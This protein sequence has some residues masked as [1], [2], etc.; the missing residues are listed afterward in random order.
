MSSVQPDRLSS[1]DLKA[2]A[3]LAG[4]SVRLVKYVLEGKRGGR[5]TALQRRIKQLVEVKRRLNQLFE[6]FAVFTRT[7]QEL[8][9]G[10]DEG[11]H[12]MRKLLTEITATW[13]SQ[14]PNHE[15]MFA[16][17][18]ELRCT[19]WNE[20]LEKLSGIPASAILGKTRSEIW[21]KSE[22]GQFDDYYRRVLNG[23]SLSLGPFDV[24]SATEPGK[25]S[26]FV[27]NVVPISDLGGQVV[28]GLVIVRALVV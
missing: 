2:I 21:V 3:N 12:I 25:I 1:H 22:W 13:M 18:R 9:I 14:T 5:N 8:Q 26:H 28:G 11:G 19:M 6:D 17:D 23:E 20:A 15:G 24:A 10:A 7:N 4:C 16:F 27:L